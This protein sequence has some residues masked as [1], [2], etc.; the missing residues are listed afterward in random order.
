MTNGNTL[1]LLTDERRDPAGEPASSIERPPA[2][3][4]DPP[5]SGTRRWLGTLPTHRRENHRLPPP[6]L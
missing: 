3:M 2:P 5:S 1:E 4:S 6:F